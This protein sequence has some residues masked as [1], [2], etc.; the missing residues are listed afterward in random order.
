MPHKIR[1]K[2]ISKNSIPDFQLFDLPQIY[3]NQITWIT[4]IDERNYDWLVV[5]DDLPPSGNER[6][7][8]NLEKLACPSANTVLLTYEPSSIKF[9][10]AD[11]VEQY[12]ML[13]TSHDVRSLPHANR[14]DCPPIG[15]W[16]YGGLE[17]V[18]KHAKPPKKTELISMFYSA[19]AQKHSLHQRRAVFLSE[20]ID[21]LS[22]QISVF[23]KGY[24]YVEHKAEGIDAFRYHIAVENHIGDHH[25]TEKLSDAFL[26]YSLPFYSGCSNAEDYFP[27]ESFIPI[28]IR[29]TQASL[30]IIKKAIAD[31]AYKKRLPAII[32]ARR[33]VIEDYNL[34]NMLGRRILESEP[35]QNRKGGEI[36]SRHKMQRRDIPTFLRYAW[37]KFSAR[38]YNKKYWNMFL[39]T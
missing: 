5:Y 28:D 9:Y 15:I 2:I 8:Q 23:G 13:L 7:T 29:D 18:A 11:Y 33:R 32:E 17:Q 31:G 14:L 10:G 30:K 22:D 3:E 19:K 1:V 34:G 20:L 24:N 6:L 21:D 35:S 12:G 4:D 36:L 37:E 16:Y 25:W 26:G 38:R 27:K 39:K